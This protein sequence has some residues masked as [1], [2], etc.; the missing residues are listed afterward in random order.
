VTLIDT[1]WQ[2]VTIGSNQWKSVEIS[3]ARL[4]AHRLRSI[5]EEGEPHALLTGAVAVTVGRRG[6][7]RVVPLKV[8]DAPRLHACPVGS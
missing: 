6:T 8:Q 7:P 3:E 1:R 5:P 4:F 2:S